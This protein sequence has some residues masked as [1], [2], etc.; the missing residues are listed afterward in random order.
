MVTNI[1]F[2]LATLLITTFSSTVLTTGSFKGSKKLA[3]WVAEC[4]CWS[5]SQDPSADD[6]FRYPL[7]STCG[8]SYFEPCWKFRS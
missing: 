2:F 8:V 7:T 1:L 4:L 3:L 6:A 5:I